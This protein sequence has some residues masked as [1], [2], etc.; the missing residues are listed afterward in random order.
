MMQWLLLANLHVPFCVVSK[1]LTEWP[2]PN[3]RP[4][5]RRRP[6]SCVWSSPAS[7]FEPALACVAQILGRRVLV[8]MEGERSRLCPDPRAH[9]Q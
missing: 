1:H 8:G 5:N 4:R 2:L 7:S 6:A 9:C 3:A